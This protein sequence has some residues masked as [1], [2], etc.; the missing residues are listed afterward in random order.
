M[1]FRPTQVSKLLGTDNDKEQAKRI[2]AMLQAS[3]QPVHSITVQYDGRNDQIQYNL[4]GPP[5]P[6]VL[7][8]LILQ[9]VIESTIQE[10]AAQRAAAK[11]PVPP[12]PPTPPA[13]A[14]AA[15]AA[16]TDAK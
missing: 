15:T 9:R 7:L 12:A 16:P 10:E 3:Q 5:I 14:D 6:F 2:T 4:I 11:M 1:G 13:P 8:R